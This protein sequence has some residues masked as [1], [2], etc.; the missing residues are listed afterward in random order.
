MRF[1]FLPALRSRPTL[2]LSHTSI[3]S[4]SPFRRSV[5]KPDLDTPEKRQLIPR[6][7]ERSTAWANDKW[8]ELRLKPEKSLSRRAWVYGEKLKDLVDAEEWFLKAVPGVDEVDWK[9]VDNVKVPV[10]MPSIL[11]PTQVETYIQELLSKRAPLHSRDLKFNIACIP[12]SLLF[13]V[14]PGPNLPLAWN[15][16]RLYSHWRA[17][18]GIT[19]LERLHS[20]GRLEYILD[21]GMDKCV[22]EWDA[23]TDMIPRGVIEKMVET[24]VAEEA[25]IRE[26]ERLDKQLKKQLKKEASNSVDP[27]PSDSSS[28]IT[29]KID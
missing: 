6:I 25:L 5:T 21:E 26:W 28:S 10:H 2:L 24:Q 22:E 19:T 3:T 7:T 12:F 17:L 1:V 18:Q 11:S 14:V 20:A 29:K 27:P 9:T 16:F 23:A 13:A 15:L 8:E 4:A